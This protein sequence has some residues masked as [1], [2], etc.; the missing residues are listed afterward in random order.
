MKHRN[1]PRG[2]ASNLLQDLL[3]QAY[4]EG[5]EEGYQDGVAEKDET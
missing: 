5:Y 4:R 1:T 2:G 3:D